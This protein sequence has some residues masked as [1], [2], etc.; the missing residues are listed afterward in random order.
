MVEVCQ[1]PVASVAIRALAGI[2]ALMSLGLVL[3][4]LSLMFYGGSR[5]EGAVVVG[6]L[7]IAIGS[8][9]LALGHVSWRVGG[10]L[11]RNLS[12]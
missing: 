4:G 10:L 6:I 3:E 12:R 1:V 9:S 7:I 8:V 11:G 2:W 5:E